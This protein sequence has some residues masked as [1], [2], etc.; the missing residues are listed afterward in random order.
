M[1]SHW[2]EKHSVEVKTK[3]TSVL[4]FECYDCKITFNCYETLENHWKEKH[5]KQKP[6][7]PMTK[8]WKCEQCNITFSSQKRL[9]RHKE[10]HL[11]ETKMKQ[12]DQVTS[13]LSH[14]SVKEINVGDNQESNLSQVTQVSQDEVIEEVVVPVINVEQV[15]D[16][17]SMLVKDTILQPEEPVTVDL[18]G[19]TSVIDDTE[20]KRCDYCDQLFPTQ[21]VLESHIKTTHFPDTDTE[22]LSQTVTILKFKCDFCDSRFN[23]E[24]D[25]NSHLLS[26][27]KFKC[28][29]CQHQFQNKKLLEIHVKEVHMFK[30][31]KCKKYFDTQTLINKHWCIAKGG[32]CATQCPDCEYVFKTKAELDRHLE[33]TREQK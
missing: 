9:E 24:I 7:T 31:E 14:P 4:K 27:Y 19:D 33:L 8:E 1:Q 30:C 12:S 29:K 6:V 16:A 10:I 3:K 26:H 28:D 15:P 13:L 22:N 5:S 23:K 21:M 25:L 11:K 20:S 32:R 18:C 17:L 2:K